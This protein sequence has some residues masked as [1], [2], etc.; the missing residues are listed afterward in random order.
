[1]N[2]ERKKPTLKGMRSNS[3][4]DSLAKT[5]IELYGVITILC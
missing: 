3:V 1:M 2:Q 5:L 4:S